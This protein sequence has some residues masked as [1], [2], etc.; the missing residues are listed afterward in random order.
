M[1]VNMVLK[2]CHA[3]FAS[4]TV[5]M[6]AILMQVRTF[7]QA[8]RWEATLVFNAGQKGQNRRKRREE[9][10]RP[11]KRKGASPTVLAAAMS[12]ST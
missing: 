1:I 4:Q 6:T 11:K 9:A 8:R 3:R 5:L 12:V 10:D 2:T 7:R